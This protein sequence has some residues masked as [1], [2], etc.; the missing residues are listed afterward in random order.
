MSKS[1]GAIA[2]SDQVPCY[3]SVFIFSLSLRHIR[4]R[5]HCAEAQTSLM[6]LLCTHELNGAFVYGSPPITLL[7]IAASI[8]SLIT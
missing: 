8:A 1:A 7:Q 4:V 3:S 6:F 2:S 5:V